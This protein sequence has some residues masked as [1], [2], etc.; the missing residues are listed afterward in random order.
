[1]TFDELETLIATVRDRYPRSC[2]DAP[3]AEIVE[4]LVVAL[5]LELEPEP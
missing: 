2:D 3:S 1:M 5:A 4:A